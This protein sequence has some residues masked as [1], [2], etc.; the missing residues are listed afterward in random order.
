M[1]LNVAISVADHAALIE[2]LEDAVR[3]NESEAAAF[4]L[5]PEAREL[6]QER[7]AK[8]RSAERLLRLLAKY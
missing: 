6:A 8:A 7:L 4:L 5:L 3:R 2:H 1:K